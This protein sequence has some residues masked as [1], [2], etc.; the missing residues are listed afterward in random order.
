[1]Y[2]ALDAVA[3]REVPRKKNMGLKSMQENVSKC[4]EV[5]KETVGI[6]TN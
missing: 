6:Q 1:M 4:N 2:G 3:T 5:D